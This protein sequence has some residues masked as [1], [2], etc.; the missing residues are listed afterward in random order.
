M[1]CITI[2]RKDWGNYENPY[3]EDAKGAKL[4]EEKSMI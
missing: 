1:N 3:R 2:W 4:R